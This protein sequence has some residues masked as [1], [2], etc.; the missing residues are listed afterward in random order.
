CCVTLGFMLFYERYYEV[1]DSYGYFAGAQGRSFDWSTVGLGAGTYTV[2]ALAWLHAQWLVASYHATKVSFA[3]VG[4]VAVFV[5]YRAACAA[6]GARRLALLFGLALFPSVLF[7]SSILGKD[8][9]AL[10]GLAIYSFGVVGWLRTGRASSLA[11]AGAGVVIAMA[12]RLWLGPICAVP[13]LVVGLRTV[14]RWPHRLALLAVGMLILVGLVALLREHFALDT[15]ADS[16]QVVSNVSTAMAVG[17]SAQLV[18]TDFTNPVELLKFLPLGFVAA[19]VRPLPGEVM[20][21]FGLLA[22]LENLFVLSLVAMAIVRT[23]W[24]EL[25]DPVIAWA[26]LFVVLWALAYAPISYHNLGAAV[27]FRLQVLPPMLVLLLYLARPR[28]PRPSSTSREL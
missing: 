13:V 17:G 21:P 19:L 23:R 2:T 28:G 16:L 25:T 9:V 3:M 5:F 15:I 10:L 14:R 27:R 8:P 4:L 11:V 12:I 24:R 7:W 26:V 6:L 20:N 1:L 22:G 18:L